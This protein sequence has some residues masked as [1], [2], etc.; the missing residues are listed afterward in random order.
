MQ[1]ALLD[2]LCPALIPEL[3][4]DIATGTAC[5]IHL[6]LIAVAAI[7]TLPYQLAVLII[8]DADLSAYMILS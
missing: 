1:H 5:D 7:R 3:C 6:A 8:H 4:T 2:L